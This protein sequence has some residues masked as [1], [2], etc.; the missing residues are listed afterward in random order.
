MSQRVPLPTHRA[1]MIRKMA[2]ADRDAV[3]AAFREHDRTALPRRIGVARRTLLTYHDL[4][5]HLVEGDASFQDNMYALRGDPA[6]REIDDRLAKLLVPYDSE[7]P[8]MRQAQAEEFYHWSDDPP[9]ATYRILLEVRVDA[10]RGAELERTWRRMAAVA[11]RRPENIAQSLARD[12]A[13]PG[14][15]FV[16]SDWVDEAS[17]DRFARAPEHRALADAMRGLDAT[18]RVTGMHIRCCDPEAD[19]RVDGAAGHIAFA[20]SRAA[21]GDTQTAQGDTQA[22]RG[23]G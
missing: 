18:V 15:Y 6:F 2:P 8:S 1:V 23:N 19:A 13:E 3:A 20:R 11:A 17:Y 9:A 12:R 10:A 22:E 7:R 4:Y 21:Q 16:I 14:V 5:I